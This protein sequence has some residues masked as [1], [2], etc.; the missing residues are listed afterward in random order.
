MSAQSPDARCDAQRVTRDLPFANAFRLGC[1]RTN[2]QLL[3]FF[4]VWA[5]VHKPVAHTLPIARHHA[6]PDGP[7]LFLHCCA[8]S[9]L[10]RSTACGR[11]ECSAALPANRASPVP[12]PLHARHAAQ[13]ARTPAC[14]RLASTQLWAVEEKATTS[15]PQPA[16]AQQEEQVCNGV[17]R[18]LAALSV[19]AWGRK[20]VLKKAWYVRE[21]S[22][23][24]DAGAEFA[25]L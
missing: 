8:T 18:A 1:T 13:G 7:P 12:S 3:F 25:A 11:D 10:Q 9:W 5:P 22:G 23:A 21:P 4:K 24:A 16:D 6:A 2:A 15:S 17:A 14:R 20:W 19:L